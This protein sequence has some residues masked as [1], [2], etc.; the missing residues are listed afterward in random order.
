MDGWVYVILFF[1]WFKELYIN[2]S[3]YHSW[4][5]SINHCINY[6]IIRLVRE[7]KSINHNLCSSYCKS[8]CHYISAK[9]KPLTTDIRHDKQYF[10]SICKSVDQCSTQETP[11][12]FTQSILQCARGGGLGL[13]RLAAGVAQASDLNSICPRAKAMNASEGEWHLAWDNH[14]HSQKYTPKALRRAAAV[15]FSRSCSSL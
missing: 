4:C 6:L 2:F 1:M 14:S 9:I 11:A 3:L 7:N 10:V 13:A 15:N 12:S 8:I 5:V